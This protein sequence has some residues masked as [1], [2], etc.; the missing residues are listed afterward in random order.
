MFSPVLLE[1]VIERARSTDPRVRAAAL[2]CAAR[3]SQEPPLEVAE[4]VA[5][6]ADPDPGVRRAGV[7]LAAN[8]E[9]AEATNALAGCLT[10][11]APEVQRTAETVLGSL[12]GAGVAAVEPYLQSESERWVEASARV[13]AASGLP[14]AR[15]RLLFELRRHVREL[16]WHLLGYQH[17]PREHH[18]G[19]RFLRAAFRDAMLRSHRLA[20]RMLELLENP[21]VIHRVERELRAG[22]T[23]SRGNALEV[24]SNLGDR[25]SARL[26][27]LVHEA[28]PLEERGRIAEAAIHPPRE[29]AELIEAARNSPLHWIRI[30]ARACR[31]REGDPPPEEVI[32]QRLLALKQVDLF[33]NLSFEQL[34]AVH[35]ATEQAEYVA[36]EVIFREDDRGD[37][38]YLL[39]EG[40]VAIIKSEGAPDGPGAT[41]Q[42]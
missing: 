40:D 30:G 9:D 3:I 17:L 28:A 10:D 37:A 41:R 16:W 42:G 26:L 1:A 35:G 25:E 31:P 36:G 32:L 33:S 27:V 19:S 23:R 2:E 21:A 38:L 18:L 7:L 8:L 15:Q 22:G 24:L 12:A 29:T 20:F 5:L 6:L 39:I 4:T 13:M 34:D 14:D 11:P